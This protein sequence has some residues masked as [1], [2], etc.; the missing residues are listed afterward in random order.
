MDML[1]N[2]V[3]GSA[4][5]DEIC[6]NTLTLIPSGPVAFDRDNLSISFFV[7][8]TVT[9]G[10]LNWV[11]KFAILDETYSSIFVVSN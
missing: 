1:Y 9:T 10:I 2:L 11:T 8:S 6:F 5:T 3:R 7:S 4:N